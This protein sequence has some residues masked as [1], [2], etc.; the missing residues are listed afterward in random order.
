MLSEG[1][2]KAPL[3]GCGIKLGRVNTEKGMPVP[4]LESLF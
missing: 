4:N 3:V 2:Y 1:F